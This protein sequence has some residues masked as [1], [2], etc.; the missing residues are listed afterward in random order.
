MEPP[1][2]NLAGVTEV[3]SGYM[4]G[5]TENPTYEDICGGTTGHAE[6]VRVTYDA[7]VISYE[8]LLETFWMNIDP[9]TVQGQFADIGSQ[10]RPEIFYYTDEQKT[11]AEKSKKELQESG[12][13]D[14]PVVVEITP[15]PKF[16]PAENYHQNYHE[17]NPVHY[18]MYRRGSGR[19][20]FIEKVWGKNLKT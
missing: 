8:K 11:A 13:F 12:R 5:H 17:T 6:V 19:E 2:K 9:T 18:K 3:V 16:Y 4:G 7:S 14:S 20:T 15:A 10:Y 1:F